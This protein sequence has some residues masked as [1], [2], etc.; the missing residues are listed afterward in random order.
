MTFENS[1]AEILPGQEP[2]PAYLTSLESID[3]ATVSQYGG[4]ATNLA[5][6]IREGLP[7][8]PG[9]VI[10]TAAFRSF[11]ENGAVDEGCTHEV[12][13]AIDYLGGEVALR[14][15]ANNEDSEAASMAGI[16][17]THYVRGSQAKEGVHGILT[18]MYEQARSVEVEQSAALYGAGHNDIELAIVVQKL[19]PEP[20]RAGVIYADAKSGRTVVQYVK[21]YGAD[22]V[23][24]KTSGSAILV[25]RD[26]STIA[27]SRNYDNNPLSN[28]NLKELMAM[29]QKIVDMGKGDRDIEFAVGSD[30]KAW[31]LQDRPLPGG[32]GEVN[33]D[34]TTYELVRQEKERAAEIIAAEMRDLGTEKVI[35]SQANFSELLPNPTAM[36]EGVFAYIFPGYNGS[37]GAI[38]LGRQK[39]GYPLGEA[40]VGYMHRIGGRIYESLA[41]DAATYFAGFPETE[42]EYI[43]TF[44]NGYL[45]AAYEDPTRAS[46]PEMGLYVQ[47]PTIEDLTTMF[48]PERAPILMK[49]YGVFKDGVAHYADVFLSD[50]TG[51][52]GKT[53]DDFIERKRH[54]E[55]S[56]LDNVQLLASFNEILDHLRDESCTDFVIAAR[57]GFYYTQRLTNF[58]KTTHGLDEEAALDVVSRL[59]QG[60]DGSSVT[61]INRAISEASTDN[62]A[63]VVALRA[64][65]H[66]P[67][68][69]EILQLRHPR[70]SDS[71]SQAM[72]YVKGIRSGG[73][74]EAKLDGQKQERLALQHELMLKTPASLRTE[75]GTMMH[76]S[77][78]YM[79]LRETIKD[80][81]TKEY[82]LLRD[83]LTEMA[84]KSGIDKDGI[85]HLYPD[86]LVALAKS[87][88]ATEHIINARATEF[89]LYDKLSM[90]RVLRHDNLDEISQR[91][92][93]NEYFRHAIGQFIAPGATVEGAVVNLEEFNGS[94]SGEVLD[95]MEKLRRQ[96]RKIILAAQQ[97]NLT[98]DG[99][100]NMSDGIV[101]QNAGFVSHGAQ[102]AREL[103]VGAL[104]G[105]EV[106]ALITGMA[107]RFDPEGRSVTRIDDAPESEVTL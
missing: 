75:L 72:N 53:T 40:S 14:S 33:L 43:D 49:A 61:D 89:A 19:V 29:T 38:Q 12:L 24:G 41:R 100:I 82:A 78:S 87:P 5:A 18:S 103:G 31:I 99:Y 66:Y 30:G 101:L 81:F 96:G 7:V 56:D 16:F 80:Q 94:D 95:M 28:D 64:A 15:S 70:L 10:G 102:R 85:F 36:D 37:A 73:E 45:E 8:P 32:L 67:V 60:L 98:H 69:G 58:L 84:A 74:Y 35:L 68:Q 86:E 105:I 26:T 11:V 107:V 34:T 9:F 42:Q 59:S 52:R 62:E 54:E 46:Y 17:T 3:P 71:P 106:G 20:I 27:Q 104:S 21:G 6:L 63:L 51:Q 4:K 22:L 25:D 92:T 48:G 77:Q 90:P 50:Y 65:Y 83:R 88:G 55:L 93:P 39:M 91:Q 23:D 44:V 1:G 76:S 97:V 47:D 2:G 79:A 57:L 13:R